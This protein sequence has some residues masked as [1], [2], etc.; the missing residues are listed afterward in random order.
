MREQF[1]TILVNNECYAYYH[2][3]TALLQNFC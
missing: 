3:F 2:Y 1:L